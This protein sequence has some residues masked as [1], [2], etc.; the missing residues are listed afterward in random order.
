MTIS[1]IPT[2]IVRDEPAER[3]VG[4]DFG[5]LEEIIL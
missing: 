4:F 3:D 5:E 2:L 1:G